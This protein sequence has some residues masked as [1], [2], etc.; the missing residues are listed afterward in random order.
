VWP[1]FTQSPESMSGIG[2]VHSQGEKILA[3]LL[4]GRPPWSRG[5]RTRA[6]AGVVGV[7]LLGRSCSARHWGA[8]YEGP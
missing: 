3:L 2:R 4:I 5:V 1:H 6:P 8:G 7:G